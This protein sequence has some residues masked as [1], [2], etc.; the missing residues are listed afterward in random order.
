MEVGKIWRTWILNWL[1]VN[2]S[3]TRWFVSLAEFSCYCKRHILAWIHVPRAILREDRLRRLTPGV[4]LKKSQK[5]SG[6]HRKDM[7]PLTQGLSYRSACDYYSFNRPRRD[8]RLSWPC[9][10]TDSGRFTHKVVT[11]PAVRLAQDRKS[12]PSK[13]VGHYATPPTEHAEF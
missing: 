3:L 4:F 7:S 1:E 11:W 10:L 8:G 12:S 9:W 13:T 6:S 5:V 2:A